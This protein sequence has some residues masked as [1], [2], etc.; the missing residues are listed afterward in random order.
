MA[1]LIVGEMPANSGLSSIRLLSPR[2][3]FALSGGRSPKSLRVNLRIFP[4]FGDRGRR[5]W[6]DRH[7]VP[8]TRSATQRRRAVL[9]GANDRQ[10]PAVFPSFSCRRIQPRAQVGPLW[11]WRRDFSPQPS[12]RA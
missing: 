7:C 8:T 1:S 4:F 5:Q 2:S 10:N 11:L 12:Y 3:N 6:F 9:S